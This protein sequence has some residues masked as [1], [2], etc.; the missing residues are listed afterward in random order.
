MLIGANLFWRL[1]CVGQIKAS[2]KHPTLQ[3][4]RFGWILAGRLGGPFNLSQNIQTFYARACT[5]ELQ[6]QVARFWQIE[7]TNE[8]PTQLTYEESLCE[9]HYEQNVSQAPDDWYITKL[10]I[11]DHVLAKLGDSREVALKRLHEFKR[12]F[13]RDPQLNDQYSKFIN[14]YL[15]LGHMRPVD[16]RLDDNRQPYYLPHH[17]V[18]KSSWEG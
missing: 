10:P 4:T 12:R 17:C 14:E 11:K 5:N 18:F 16:E 2:I 3:K 9:Q 1:L 8:T 7:D 15:A 6:E 13:K